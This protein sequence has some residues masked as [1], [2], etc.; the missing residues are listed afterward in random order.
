MPRPWPV[1]RPSAES[2]LFPGIVCARSPSASDAAFTSVSP[3]KAPQA[4]LQ[5]Q[6]RR[7]ADRVSGRP[8]AACQAPALVGFDKSKNNP[9]HARAPTICN[10]LIGVS[11]VRTALDAVPG[12]EVAHLA[13]CTIG[14]YSDDATPCS[15]RSDSLRHDQHGD[16]AGPEWASPPS[17]LNQENAIGQTSPSGPGSL[18]RRKVHRAGPLKRRSDVVR[19]RP[20]PAHERSGEGTSLNCNA[21]LRS[22]VH[23]LAFISI[24]CPGE[25]THSRTFT[26]P[27][28]LCET[29]HAFSFSFSAQIGR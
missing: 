5:R 29:R 10:D 28:A 20:R 25:R 2:K 1:R 4:P 14:R 13:G 7:T 21:P 12:L 24:S 23:H 3:N 6:L 11:A 26:P 15:R 17:R 9:G 22:E 19:T 16:A 18:I 27:V 8:S